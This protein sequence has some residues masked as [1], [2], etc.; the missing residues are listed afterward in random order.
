MLG[1]ALALYV[2]LS[3]VRGQVYARSG[4]WGRDFYRDTDGWRYWSAIV[5]Y[6]LLSAALMFVF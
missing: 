4:M 1:V 2:A 3:L 5:A 6:T